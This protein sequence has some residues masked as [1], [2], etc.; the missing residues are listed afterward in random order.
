[1]GRA[2][3]GIAAGPKMSAGRR[4]RAPPGGII[5]LRL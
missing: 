5:Y 4:E 2:L 3:A 1:M